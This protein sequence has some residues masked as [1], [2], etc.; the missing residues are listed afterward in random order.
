MVAE[1]DLTGSTRGSNA[2]TPSELERVLCLQMPAAT[3]G[4][5]AVFALSE[6][7]I[8]GLVIA[9]PEGALTTVQTYSLTDGIRGTLLST[10]LASLSVSGVCTGIA[11]MADHLVVGTDNGNVYHQ[12]TSTDDQ[13][14]CW[15]VLSCVRQLKMSYLNKELVVLAVGTAVRSVNNCVI[16]WP[17]EN[18]SAIGGS[19]PPRRKIVMADSSRSQPIGA[20]I[21]EGLV[22]VCS[23]S[24]EIEMYN[25]CGVLLYQLFRR[26][27]THW[28]TGGVV[29]LS[30]RNTL[31]SIGQ[32]EPGDAAGTTT[33]VTSTAAPTTVVTIAIMTTTA[34]VTT[35][36]ATPDTT[37]TATTTATGTTAGTTT[38]T[39][40]A[41]ITTTA[42]T[43][44]TTTT[45]AVPCT[46]TGGLAGWDRPGGAGEAR[47]FEHQLGTPTRDAVLQ[48]LNHKYGA[49]LRAVKHTASVG[50]CKHRWSV[51]L[52]YPGGGIDDHWLDELSIGA[53]TCMLY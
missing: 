25:S 9:T 8:V 40:A 13:P 42:T 53:N 41:T 20:C 12:H 11:L 37:T 50:V 6:D 45:T 1:A 48:P 47:M 4:A 38:A 30:G 46:A 26:P 7:T 28:H 33:L 43:T 39:T 16:I 36:A 49:K 17:V 29:H 15:K 2:V 24:G 5:A 52:L 27:S 10:Q 35:A 14:T 34:A 21:V 19:G 32:H 22:A 44:A 18:N 31:V 51:Q 3:Y 23:R